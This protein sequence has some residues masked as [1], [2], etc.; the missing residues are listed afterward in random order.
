M[1]RKSGEFEFGRLAERASDGKPTTADVDCGMM[2]GC[3]EPG[4]PGQCC[5]SSTL[6][7]GCSFLDLSICYWSGLRLAQQDSWPTFLA[8]SL[9]L[10]SALPAKL[11]VVAFD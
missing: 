4:K 5:P 1:R 6:V 8:T 7:A 2:Q 3:S 11:W 9:S 10:L